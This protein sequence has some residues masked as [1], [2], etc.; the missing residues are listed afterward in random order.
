MSAPDVKAIAAAVASGFG[1]L[2][3]PTGYA[4]IRRA[5]DARPNSIATFPFV[6]VDLP[7]GQMVVMG[8]GIDI[9]LNFRARLWL[10]KHTADQA[11]DDAVLLAWCGVLIL[12][13]ATAINTSA[14]AISGVKSALAG[15]FRYFHDDY[16]ST[17]DCFGWEFDITT[18]LR[19]WPLA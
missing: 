17:A 11:R 14:T 12:A 1:S 13:G 10:A 16:A 3:P 6:T 2:T 7:D 19:N 9:T 4:A 18:M 15:D 5:T 8:S